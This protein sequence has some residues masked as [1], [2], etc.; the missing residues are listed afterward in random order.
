MSKKD[1]KNNVPIFIS[2]IMCI[3]C[4]AYTAIKLDISPVHFM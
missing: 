4:I 3:L 1:K 2:I